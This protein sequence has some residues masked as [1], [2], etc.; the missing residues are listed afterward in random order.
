[1][2]DEEWIRSAEYP[3]LV[4]PALHG[5]AHQAREEVLAALLV[6]TPP[7]RWPHVYTGN[8]MVDAAPLFL[9]LFPPIPAVPCTALG[10]A[11]LDNWETEGL[12]TS[13]GT[14]SAPFS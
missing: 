13:L 6:G 3:S 14:P 7:E 5:A 1:V 8:V 2:P 9:P 11:L 12:P 10:R 4:C